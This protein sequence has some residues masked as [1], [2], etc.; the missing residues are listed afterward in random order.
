LPQLKK[1]LAAMKDIHAT[2]V[3][4]ADVDYQQWYCLP[5]RGIP[6]WHAAPGKYVIAISKNWETKK[7]A[8]QRHRFLPVKHFIK[9]G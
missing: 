3:T 9:P 4:P 8:S 6:P 2:P 5:L 1:V 7:T